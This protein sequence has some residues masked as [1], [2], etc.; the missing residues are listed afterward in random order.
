[1]L[2]DYLKRA[3]LI[4]P[5]VPLRFL[6]RREQSVKQL[7]GMGAFS[8]SA[9]FHRMHGLLFVPLHEAEVVT[10]LSDEERVALTEFHRQFDSLPWRVIADHPHI[11]E[12]PDDDLSPLVPSGERL[13]RL[14]ETRA[15]RWS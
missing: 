9:F 4:A 11:S 13:L 3:S 14:L 15:G 5:R 2:S 7:N 10:L 12:L 1:M 8:D 6:V